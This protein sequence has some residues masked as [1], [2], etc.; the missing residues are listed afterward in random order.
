MSRQINGW[1]LQFKEKWLSLSLQTHVYC[2]SVALCFCHLKKKPLAAVL[3]RQIEG[4]I[5]VLSL[6]RRKT[7]KPSK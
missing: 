5:F 2:F 6:Y 3:T 1:V 7:V 4:N